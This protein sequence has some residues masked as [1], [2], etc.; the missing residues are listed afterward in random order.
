M[1]CYIFC[2]LVNVYFSHVFILS[3]IYIQALVMFYGQATC[4]EL[5]F[6][7]WLFIET[8]LLLSV[9]ILRFS[10]RLIYSHY[11]I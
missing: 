2:Y 9:L 7:M 1:L 4:N 3:I 8:P 11:I 10:S 5:L 6:I